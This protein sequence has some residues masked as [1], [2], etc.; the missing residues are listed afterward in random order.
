MHSAGRTSTIKTSF[1][2]LLQPSS[3]TMDRLLGE[4]ASALAVR[5]RDAAALERLRRELR[6]IVIHSRE[7]IRDGLLSISPAVFVQVM[8]SL[9]AR[10]GSA[11]GEGCA[12]R[13]AV[14]AAASTLEVGGATP[15]GALRPD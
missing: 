9:P 14:D 12:S 11:S 4:I 5:Q 6:R 8:D 10:R 2:L 15:R 1:H 7:K 3:S 13:S